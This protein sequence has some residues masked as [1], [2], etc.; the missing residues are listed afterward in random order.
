MSV[1][2]CVSTIKTGFGSAGLDTDCACSRLAQL[3]WI[4]WVLSLVPL[5][6]INCVL[7]LRV[8]GFVTS[9]LMRSRVKIPIEIHKKNTAIRDEDNGFNIEKYHT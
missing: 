6:L 1:E 9:E 7:S 2:A 5:G 4:I 8:I 3:D